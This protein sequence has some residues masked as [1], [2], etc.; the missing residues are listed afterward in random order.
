MRGTV[1]LGGR[2]KEKRGFVHLSEELVIMG[3]DKQTRKNKVFHDD[4]S[5]YS[6][7][8]SSLGSCLCHHATEN[9]SGNEWKVYMSSL[10]FLLG[11]ETEVSSAGRQI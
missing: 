3:S 5:V 11:T 4:R 9:V 2:E 10:F 1:C 7:W 6:S 8:C